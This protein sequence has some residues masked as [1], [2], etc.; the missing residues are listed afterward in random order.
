MGQVALKGAR[1]GLPGKRIW[2]KAG[3]IKS[4][5]SQYNTF[6]DLID[7]LRIAGANIIEVEIPSAEE[8]VPINGGWDWYKQYFLC[9]PQIF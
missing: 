1:F 4:A 2:Q 8:M 7:R 6:R 5:E 3:S 9:G